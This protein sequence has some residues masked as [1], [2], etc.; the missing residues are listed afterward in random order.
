MIEEKITIRNKDNELLT[1]MVLKPNQQDNFPAIVFCHDY[2]DK[3]DDAGNRKLLGRLVGENYVVVAFDFAGHGSSEGKMEDTR[4][5]KWLADLK[6]MV[7]FAEALPQAQK[8]NIAIIGKGMGATTS[9]MLAAEDI[10]VKCLVMINVI[11]DISLNKSKY[12]TDKEIW[13]KKDFHDFSSG[14]TGSKLR[15]KPTELDD[16]SGRDIIYAAKKITCPTILIYGSEDLA[17][18]AKESADLFTYLREPKQLEA[19]DE[20]DRD[21]SRPENQDRV[22]AVITK[23]LDQYLKNDRNI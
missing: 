1:G 10:R 4:F 13:R 8:R 12:P 3:R 7:N 17:S 14:S 18:G 11:S 6:S 19:I 23:W 20:A 22:I 16:L 5:V 9:L 15:L 21:F 2:K